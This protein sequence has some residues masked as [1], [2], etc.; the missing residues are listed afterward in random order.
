MIIPAPVEHL[1]ESVFA[2]FSIAVFA[3]FFRLQVSLTLDVMIK[4][5]SHTA[6]PKQA[7]A[8]LHRRL[9]NIIM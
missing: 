5:V 3:H 8:V 9:A 7:S 6:E 4:T 2:M 1:D